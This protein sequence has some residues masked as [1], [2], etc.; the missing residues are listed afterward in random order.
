MIAIAII[1]PGYLH[2][3]FTHTGGLIALVIG[4]FMIATGSVLIGKIVDI[5][6]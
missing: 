4:G 5:E 2:P 6:V 1:S 3:M